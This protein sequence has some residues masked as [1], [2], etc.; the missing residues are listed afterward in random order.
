MI[1]LQELYGFLINKIITGEEWSNSFLSF[2]AKGD[3]E[4]PKANLI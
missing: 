2:F 1:H 3:V 4:L